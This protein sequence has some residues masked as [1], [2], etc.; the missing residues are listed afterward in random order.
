MD[1]LSGFFSL[2]PD[3]QN[4]L[5]DR[6]G[7]DFGGPKMILSGLWAKLLGEESSEDPRWSPEDTQMSPKGPLYDPRGTLKDL[8][9][10]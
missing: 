9:G 8:E 10:P 1:S 3:Q 2:Y 4:I 7:S 5:N 6:E